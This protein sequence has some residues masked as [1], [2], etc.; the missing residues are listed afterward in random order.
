MVTFSVAAA[1][2]QT[3]GV[4]GN[5]LGVNIQKIDATEGYAESLVHAFRLATADP[6]IQGIFFGALIAR[7]V[8]IKVNDKEG[9]SITISSLKTLIKFLDRLR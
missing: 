2:G 8:A 6:F 5:E 7:N 1:D 3:V 9:L 4:V